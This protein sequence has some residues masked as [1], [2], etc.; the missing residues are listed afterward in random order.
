MSEDVTMYRVGNVD[1]TGDTQV[2]AGG[3]ILGII[4]ELMAR[5]RRITGESFTGTFAESV[6]AEHAGCHA[7]CG[8]LA[9]SED[10]GGNATKRA[11]TNIVAADQRAGAGLGA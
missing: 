10:A 5:V 4:D 1:A 3:S 9:A 6:I 7:D 2:S 8:A 11:A